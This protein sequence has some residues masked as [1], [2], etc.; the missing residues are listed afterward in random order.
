[1]GSL[2]EAFLPKHAAKLSKKFKTMFIE[3]LILYVVITITRLSKTTKMF[4]NPQ[5]LDVTGLQESQVQ[6]RLWKRI[7]LFHISS[8]F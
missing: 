8:I 6:D 5:N 7:F 1:M 4:Q 2:A 3:T